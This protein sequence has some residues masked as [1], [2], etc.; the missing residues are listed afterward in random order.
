MNGCTIGGRDHTAGAGDWG[1]VCEKMRRD[2]GFCG[3]CTASHVG[4]EFSHQRPARLGGFGLGPNV[5]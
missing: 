1:W 2:L 5:S 3:D 4:L